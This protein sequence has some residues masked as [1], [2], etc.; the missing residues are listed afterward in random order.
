M[1]RITSTQTSTDKTCLICEGEGQIYSI[2]RFYI[3]DNGT[4]VAELVPCFAC[5]GK[6]QR[7]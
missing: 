5:F 2:T 7:K 6:G 1:F 3:D 4:C